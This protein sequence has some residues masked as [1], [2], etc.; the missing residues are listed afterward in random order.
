MRWDVRSRTSPS[1]GKQQRYC[2]L[3]GDSED[4]IVVGAHL[5]F[6]KRGTGIMDDWSGTAL[7]P[8]LYAALK[9]EQRHHTFQFI[10]FTNE[11]K[12]LRGSAKYVKAAT[13][14]ELTSIQ[15]F[16]NIECL[17][18]GPTNVWVHRSTPLLVSRLGEMAKTMDIPFHGVDL[19]RF[20][21]D[22]THPFFSKKVPVISIHS[23]TPETFG[24]L[25]TSRDNY[26]AVRQQDYYTSYKLLAFYLAYLD[27]ALGQA[28]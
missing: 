22:D 21:D 28:K 8:S 27:R 7:L 12:G 3:K 23:V 17:G 5:D 24:L 16:V 2:S 26:G 9:E 20:G 6:I 19:D 4:A 11:E 25:H 18:L 1:T 15:A 13:G 10:A 14:A